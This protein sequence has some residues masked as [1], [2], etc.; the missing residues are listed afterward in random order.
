MALIGYARVSTNRQDTRLQRDALKQTGVEKIFQEKASGAKN[1]R[2]ELDKA[3]A[4]LREGDVLVVWKLDRLARSLK[5]LVEIVD[6]LRQRGV[7]FKVLTGANIDTTTSGGRLVF[8]IFA[9][10]AE[11]EREMI[12][13]RVKAGLESARAAGKHLG[14]PQLTEQRQ[15]EIRGRLAAGEPWRSISRAMGVSQSTIARYAKQASHRQSTS[16]AA[17]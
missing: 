9:S 8:G 10:L 2:P 15:A 13:E 11:F 6:D 1:D 14:R 12:Q 16:R 3:L 5:H 7:G 17:R 4:Y